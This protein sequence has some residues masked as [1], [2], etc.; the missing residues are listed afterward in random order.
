[1]ILDL[2]CI[3][4]L[5]SY[6]VDLSGW[7]ASWKGWLSRILGGRQIKSLPPFD[8]SLCVAWWGG[9]A[10]LLVVGEFSL[11]WVCVVGLL[12]LSTSVITTA[13]QLTLDIVRGVLVK[14]DNFLNE[15]IW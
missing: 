15:K 4:L 8:C 2:L 12:S 7:T 13:L 10:Y 14:I 6:I 5:S 1:M 3:A 11:R 9:I